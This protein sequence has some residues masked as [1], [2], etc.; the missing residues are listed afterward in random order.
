MGTVSS[1][2]P[3]VF[4]DTSALVALFRTRD[5]HYGRARTISEQMLRERTI[6]ITTEM[7]IAE[8]ITVLSMRE[9]K[10]TAVRFWDWLQEE[11]IDVASISPKIRDRAFEI[12][13]RHPSK[14]FPFFDAV[15][16][17]L[18][19]REGITH[20]FSFDRHFPRRLP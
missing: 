20:A 13:T 3:R 16:L 2:P 14:N 8:T 10:E 19:E 7:V 15:S 11:D 18:M 1:F 6:G 17:A 5:V 4:V 9:S 12:F